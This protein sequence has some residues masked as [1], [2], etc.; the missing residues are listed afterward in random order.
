MLSALT[1][2][3]FPESQTEKGL[4]QHFLSKAHLT[5]DVKDKTITFHCDKMLKLITKGSHFSSLFFLICLSVSEHGIKRLLLFSCHPFLDWIMLSAKLVSRCIRGYGNGKVKKKS[6]HSLIENKQLHTR[7]Q[8]GSRK[9]L[10]SGGIVQ[11]M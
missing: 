8:L 4:S 11:W 9:I 6:A 7:R 3:V 5:G 1:G 2:N 10:T